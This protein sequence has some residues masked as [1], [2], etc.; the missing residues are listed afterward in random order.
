MTELFAE[1]FA[2][3][4]HTA[5]LELIL[6]FANCFPADVYPDNDDLGTSQRRESTHMR[7]YSHDDEVDVGAFNGSMPSSSKVSTIG[8]ALRNAGSS[9][10]GRRTG[11][12]GG[13]GGTS[14]RSA[15]S[16]GLP[17]RGGS[18]SD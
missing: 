7:R 4:S 10:E 2:Q 14:K 8:D 15:G 5:R 16:K 9:R 11:T 6:S 1:L 12:R 17:R 3:K 13:S 18:D